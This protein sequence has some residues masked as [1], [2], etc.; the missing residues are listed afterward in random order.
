VAWLAEALW[1][2]AY[3][4]YAAEPL[5]EERRST[6]RFEQLQIAQMVHIKIEAISLDSTIINVHPDGTGALKKRTTGDWQIPR[7][8]DN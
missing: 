4:A 3:G 5:V 7:R 2:L 6:A 8:M 1:K